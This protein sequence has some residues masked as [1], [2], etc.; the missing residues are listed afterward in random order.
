MHDEAGL[1]QIIWGKGRTSEENS[2]SRC[3]LATT[4]TINPRGAVLS[5]GGV[6]EW[7]ANKHHH[8]W[9]H[10]TSPLQPPSSHSQRWPN[11]PTH[12]KQTDQSDLTGALG[13]M[14]KRT[15]LVF[16]TIS[17][18]LLSPP[19]VSLPSQK[20]PLGQT[21]THQWKLGIISPSR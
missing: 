12:P 11:P 10:K 6:E 8:H 4:T 2:L 14:W 21:L 13:W 18:L 3:C 9:T 16:S 19:S 15:Q 5:Q 20:L 7:S 1:A 17:V